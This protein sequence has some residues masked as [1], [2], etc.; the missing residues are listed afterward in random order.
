L[1]REFATKADIPAGLSEYTAAQDWPAA[2][3]ERMTFAFR[4]ELNLGLG[5]RW[6][7]ALANL[8][9]YAEIAESQQLLVKEQFVNLV[10]SRIEGVKGISLHA[11][12]D[13]DHLSSRAIVP[14]TVINNS[15]SFAS[16]EESQ[17][18]QLLM[19][20]L[21]EGTICH[22]GQAVR[23]GSRT[24]LRVAASAMD[25]AAVAA[26]M[27]AGQSLHQALRPIES[28]LDVFFHKLSAVLQHVRGA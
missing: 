18:I 21:N 6:I 14:L 24:V 10:R 26:R 22:V 23:L 11:D 3:R 1:A 5:L 27:T 7:A 12:D 15:G 28:R 16:L 2:L 20:N 17:N 8:D 9:R 19:R 25:V 4:S 13:G